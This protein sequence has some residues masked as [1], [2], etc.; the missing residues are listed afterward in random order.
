MFKFVKIIKT[1]KQN[2]IDG[3]VSKIIKNV[4]QFGTGYE[5]ITGSCIPYYDF[6]REYDTENERASNY[7]TDLDFAINALDRYKN[8]NRK[9]FTSSG[10]DS[11]KQKYKNSFHF[12]IRGFGYYESTNQIQKID[13][14]DPNVYNTGS[15]LFRLPYCSKE[16]QNRPLKRFNSKTNKIIEL[17]DIEEKYEEYLVQNVEGEKLIEVESIYYR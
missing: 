11:I 15:Q 7:Q 5:V 13:G 9:D 6:E 10:Y 14:F 17:D 8:C 12:R 16:K 3:D 1:K 4:K 2:I